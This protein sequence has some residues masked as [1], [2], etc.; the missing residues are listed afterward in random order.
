MI[1]APFPPAGKFGIGS[2]PS[3]SRSSWRSPGIS[4]ISSSPAT[5]LPRG[6][7]HLSA[8]H[9]QGL[10]ATKPS[11]TPLRQRHMADA[12]RN[13][14]QSPVAGD[15]P[16]NRRMVAAFSNGKAIFRDP[17]RRAL[18]IRFIATIANLLA[19]SPH[20][21]VRYLFP[22]IVLLFAGV[23]P[24]F[25]RVRLGGRVFGNA[26]RCDDASAK[27]DPT[28]WYFCRYRSSRCHPA[29]RGLRSYITGPRVNHLVVAFA[30]VG[31]AIAMTG[32]GL[33]YLQTRVGVSPRANSHCLLQ[34]RSSSPSSR[35]SIGTP[36]SSNI[37]RLD[38]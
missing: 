33:V 12:G 9:L 31:L 6:H 34:R 29:R 38:R 1:D 16:L 17:L 30:G 37:A 8:L 4:A 18:T 13:L 20:H 10:F 26:A 11:T 23:A 15:R 35:M 7:A 5:P 3:A 32:V 25:R 28:R 19:T 27:A 14:S 36:T 22:L 24:V 21:E 2:S